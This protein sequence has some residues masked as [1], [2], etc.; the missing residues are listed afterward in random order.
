M[1]DKGG[2]RSS[3]SAQRRPV[4]TPRVIIYLAV[5]NQL[6][7]ITEET[8]VTYVTTCLTWHDCV[9][10]SIDIYRST[11]EQI[12]EHFKMNSFSCL[13][14]GWQHLIILE[15]LWCFSISISSNFISRRIQYDTFHT[16]NIS[17][18]SQ[19]YSSGGCQSSSVANRA[20]KRNWSCES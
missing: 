7:D 17:T 5:E 12:T 16:H 1:F 6:N 3:N 13:N 18:I 15:H 14:K 2:N 20:D 4:F 9:K 8:M 10:N 11:G 19:M